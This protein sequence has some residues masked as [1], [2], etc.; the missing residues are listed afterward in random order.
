MVNPDY[1]YKFEICLTIWRLA[2]STAI[3]ELLALFPATKKIFSAVSIVS[4]FKE[5]KQNQ[6]I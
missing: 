6:T 5:H 2:A 3:I 4:V 1:S